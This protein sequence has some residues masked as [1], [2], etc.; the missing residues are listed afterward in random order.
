MKFAAVTAFAAAT[1]ATTA[2]VAAVDIKPMIVGGSE[3]PV[4]EKTWI[5]GVRDSK[6]GADSCGGSL[7]APTYVLTAAHCAGDWI[8]YVSVGT[9]YLSG[10]KDGQQIAVKNQYINPKNIAS[11]MTYDTLILELAEPAKYAPVKLIPEAADV[12]VNETTTV[13]GW[14][15]TAENG[16]QSDV[17]K[18]LNISVWDNAKCNVDAE[19]ANQIDETMFCAG[20]LKGEDSCQGDSGGPVIVTRD[21]E[22]HLAGVVS[23]GIGCARDG[24]PGVYSRVAKSLEFI[25]A[26]VPAIKPTN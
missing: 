6:D 12:A 26:T 7:I 1:A 22:D 16:A 14:G 4:G 15:L 5:V 21:G 24:L 19:L 11:N 17:L 20:G 9:H 25:Y 13:L 8:K 23:W 2:S 18:Q 3:V 10:S